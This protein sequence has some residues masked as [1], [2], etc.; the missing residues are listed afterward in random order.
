[1]FNYVLKKPK[2]Q[3]TLEFKQVANSLFTK[4]VKQAYKQGNISKKDYKTAMKQMKD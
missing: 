4:I 3:Q 2:Q 1:M